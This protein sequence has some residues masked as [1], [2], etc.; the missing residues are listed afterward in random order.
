MKKIL[1]A[2]IAVFSLSAANAQLAEGS[3]APD[4]TLTDINGNSFTLSEAL[5]QNKTVIIDF[6]ATWCG[7]CWGYHTTG[8]MEDLYEEHGPNGTCSDD[9]IVL[10]IEGDVTT[11]LADLQGVQTALLLK[12]ALHQKICLLTLAKAAMKQTI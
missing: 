4:F 7:P 10:Y 11:T 6:S 8:Q 5:A 12:W 2:I 3:V 9:F 1:L